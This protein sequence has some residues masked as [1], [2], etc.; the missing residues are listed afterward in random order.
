MR[1]QRSGSPLCSYYI[2][3]RR[4]SFSY[5]FFLMLSFILLSFT[6]RLVAFIGLIEFRRLIA[7][8]YLSFSVAYFSHCPFSF[9]CLNSLHKD[10]RF[11]Y[12][13]RPL[14]LICILSSS[15]R[16]SPL[17]YL[18]YPHG[19]CKW[20]SRFRAYSVKRLPGMSFAAYRFETVHID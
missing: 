16:R 5:I 15:A 2:C 10:V 3:R 6:A 18:L 1:R 7:V 8:I 12:L 4:S 13:N 19:A 20:Q 17:S 14:F 9:L 11:S